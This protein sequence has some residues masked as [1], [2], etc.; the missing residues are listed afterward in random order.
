MRACIDHVMYGTGDLDAA[1]ARI[2]A[3]LGFPAVAGGRHDAMGTENRIVALGD[4]S[5]I[6]LLA[7]AMNR[8]P[9][10]RRWAPRCWPPSPVAT[11]C[12]GGRSRSM[13]SP[14]LPGVWRWRSPPSGVKG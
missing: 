1:A 5:F 6:E 7:V 9:R 13:T 8:R 10:A 3:E 4:G 2:H 11:G 12:W 14:Q